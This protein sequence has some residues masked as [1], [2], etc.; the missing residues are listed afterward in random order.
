MKPTPAALETLSFRNLLHFHMVVSHDS[1][2]E[3]AEALGVTQ[4]TVSAQLRRLES[5]L[6]GELLRK[7]G[8]RLVPTELGSLVA[9][10]ADEIF[11][12]TRELLQAVHDPEALAAPVVKVGVADVVP[13]LLVAQLLEPMMRDEAHRVHVTM[14]HPS[15]LLADLAVH[16]LDVVIADAPTNEPTHHVRAF[17]HLLGATQL[18][19]LATPA[20]AREL[21]PGFP[22]S[23]DGAPVLLPT[24]NTVLRRSLDHWFDTLGLKPR[25]LGEFEDPSVLASV[26]ETMGGAMPA[27]SAIADQLTRR[28]AL[29][30][31][32][33]VPEVEERFYAISTERRIRHPAV[34]ALSRVARLSVLAV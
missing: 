25:V 22:R 7:E 4:P 19:F 8:R 9:R 33:E 30:L 17:N 27:A 16:R 29:D 32:A 20:L 3:A 23:L 11:G 26:A 24:P 18:S 13:Q 15:E 34:A 1:L 14:G 5:Q 28:Y 6:G 10:Y 2:N 31:I 12:V 21:A